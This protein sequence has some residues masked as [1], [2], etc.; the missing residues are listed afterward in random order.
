M[1][2]VKLGDLPPVTWV[3]SVPWV[4]CRG[5]RGRCE[6]HRVSDSAMGSLDG[7]VEATQNQQRAEAALRAGSGVLGTQEMWDL[8]RGRRQRSLKS[9]VTPKEYHG[10]S[11]H[12]V[13]QEQCIT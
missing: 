9:K 5:H 3:F 2:S 12:H 6:G 13:V 8:L 7:E 4:T 11:K 1:E 10:A